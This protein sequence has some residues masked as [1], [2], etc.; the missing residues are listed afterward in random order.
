MNSND[1]LV[2]VI[3]LDR[4]PE[5]LIKIGAQLERLGLA[6]ER[7]PAADGRT[8]SMDDP[9]LLDVA[10]FGRRHG[11]RPMAGELGCH[12]SHVWAFQRF[13]RSE[14]RWALILEDDAL[15]GPDLP[16]VLQ[17][18]AACE[19]N[20]DMVKLSGVHS[21]TPS[22]VRDLGGGYRLAVMLSRYTGSSAYLVNRHAAQTYANG[23]LPMNLPYDHAF[24]RAWAW[25]LRL[26]MVTPSPCV[27]NIAEVSV[28]HQ[29]E[30]ASRKFH[31]SRRWRT[32]GW[33]LGN[34]VQRLV[35]GLGQVLR[36]RS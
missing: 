8:L 3:N 25:K 12:V 10:E 32:Y 24:D 11:K 13:L 19:D 17:S 7:L 30:M 2:L 36:Y 27:H 23:L 22:P 1:L 20:W 31:W 4:S 18:L 5:R 9:Q 33:R 35:H 16:A 28:I 26:R 21:G 34:E 14:A 15:I 6:W 29:S